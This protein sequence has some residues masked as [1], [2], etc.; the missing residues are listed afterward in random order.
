[1]C[2]YLLY[3]H[4]PKADIIALHLE[5]QKHR[6][7][8]GYG[9]ISLKPTSK[10]R[11]RTSKALLL[12]PFLDKT[13][14]L[15]T[16]GMLVHHRKASVGGVNEELVHPLTNDEKNVQLMQNGTKRSLSTMFMGKSDSLSLA[17]MWNE[18]SDLALYYLL[19]ECGVVFCMDE[20]RLFFHRDSG[21]TLFKCV[22]GAFAGMYAS[23][24]VEVGMW[25]L[26]D[27][28]DLHELP[29]N[30]SKWDLEHGTPVEYTWQYCC[31]YGCTDV[32]IGKSTDNRCP[33]CSN[34]TYVN[35]QRG[36]GAGGKK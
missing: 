31:Y 28:Y 20:D 33:C 8:D 4:K 36:K 16:G 26:V 25:A 35:Q 17:E 23:E 27:E 34:F 12:K 11:I 21:R 1:M 30:M 2:G 29:L 32:F 10:G 9:A 24:P 18:V 6:G 14:F 13:R 19:H 15:P 5:R 3:P 7:T 22:E